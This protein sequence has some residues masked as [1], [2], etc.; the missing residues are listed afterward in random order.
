[1]KKR[2]LVSVVLMVAMLL[3]SVTA[4]AASTSFTDWKINPGGSTS[5]RSLTKSQDYT[6]PTIS[7]TKFTHVAD[8]GNYVTMYIY[9]GGTKISA[10][11]TAR[12]T[13]SGTF[14]M[15]QAAYAGDYITLKAT[16]A[17]DSQNVFYLSGT[18]N[19]Y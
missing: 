18:W 13:M 9:R 2:L 15:T 19:A 3:V 8:K 14:T 12:G 11:R 16:S 4:F 7:I 6:A 1:M 5:S 17:P 10:S